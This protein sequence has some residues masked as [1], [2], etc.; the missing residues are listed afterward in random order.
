MSTNSYTTNPLTGRT[1]RVGGPT[2]NQ[3]V[4]GAYDY[5]DGRLVRRATAPSPPAEP[6][7]YLNVET[8]RMVQWGTRTYFM[9]IRDA[10]Y[11][12]IEDYYLVPPR[13]AFVAWRSPSLLRAY[14]TE[15]RIEALDE[16]LDRL[17]HEI[18]LEATH[19]FVEPR[20]SRADNQQREAQLRRLTELNIAL[21]RECQMPVNLN[22]LP[23]NGLCEDCSKEI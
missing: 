19:Q 13:F 8:G 14:N 15:Q 17:H 21:C 18:E 20:Q 7:N 16:A 1:I 9:L 6:R 2:F 5:I 23:E 4:M 11:E 12:I 10:G 3:L 22:E